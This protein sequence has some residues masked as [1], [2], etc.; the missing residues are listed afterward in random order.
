MDLSTGAEL[1]GGENKREGKGCAPVESLI[2]TLKHDI[3]GGRAGALPVSNN[4]QTWWII[5]V[6]SDSHPH[7]PLQ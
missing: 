6:M 2:N 5:M 4:S 1:G 7:L 3:I